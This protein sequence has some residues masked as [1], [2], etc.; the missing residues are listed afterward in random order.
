MSD[1]A[2]SLLQSLTCHLRRTAM[3]QFIVRHA[4]YGALAGGNEED[5]RAADVSGALAE[6]L[7]Q[8]SGVVAINNNTLGGDPSPGNS[9]HFGAVVNVNGGDHYFACQEGQSIDFNFSEN[10]PPNGRAY[11]VVFAV[12]G[13][14]AGGNQN[15]TQAANVTAV[16]QGLLSRS[17]TV[18]C[19]N[20]SFG[21]DPSPGYSKHFAALVSVGGQT[22]VPVACQE[23]QT[24]DFSAL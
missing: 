11:S 3:T 4:I 15:S 6:Q 9:K 2:A 14:L 10:P 20:D 13:A 19:S 1:A 24:I 8:G 5:D 17:D 23:N 7:A 12:Y 18:V 21:G 16:L 22:P